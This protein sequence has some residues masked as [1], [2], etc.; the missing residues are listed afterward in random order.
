MT[1][2]GSFNMGQAW[3]R[4]LTSHIMH[5]S[6]L[7]LSPKSHPSSSGPV[8][9]WAF[10]FT[11]NCFHKEAIELLWLFLLD[12]VVSEYKNN[13]GCFI[14]CQISY[15]NSVEIPCQYI[16]VCHRPQVSKTIGA[17][18]DKWS[19]MIKKLLMRK[20]RS[21]PSLTAWTICGDYIIQFRPKL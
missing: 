21:P 13:Y 4:A 10:Y 6:A 14:A 19:V 3:L 9:E 16:V 1:L 15:G 20:A 12:L 8:M 7:G 18:V 2:R 11:W 17:V 5:W